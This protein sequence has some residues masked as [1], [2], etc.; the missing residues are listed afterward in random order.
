MA[1]RG[2]SGVTAH[3]T[4]MHRCRPEVQSLPGGPLC[5]GLVYGA[6]GLVPSALSRKAG[7]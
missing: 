5:A 3:G 7:P 1:S 6:D 4:S 2:V